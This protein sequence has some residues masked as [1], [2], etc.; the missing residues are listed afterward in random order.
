MKPLEPSKRLDVD[1]FASAIDDNEMKSTVD[2]M[3]EDLQSGFD[4]FRA[5]DFDV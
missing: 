5:D 2:G 4:G 3:L 1:V